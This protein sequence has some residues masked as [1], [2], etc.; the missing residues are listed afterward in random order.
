MLHDEATRFTQLIAGPQDEI[1]LRT[2]HDSL[3]DAKQ[4]PGHKFVGSWQ[5]CAAMIEADQQLGY[6]AYMVIN[7][8]GNTD[9]QITHH[10]ASFVDI[11]IYKGD[12]IPSVWHIEP[13]IITERRDNANA[14]Q[15]MHAYWLT[16]PG[17]DLARWTTTQKQLAQFYSSDAMVVNPSRVMRVPGTW[18]LKSVP[19]LYRLTW[20]STNCT[21]YDIGR[22]QGGLPA[23][24]T[25]SP[26]VPAGERGK[27][28]LEADDPQTQMR[29]MTYL[30]AVDPAVEGEGGDQ[31][32][33]A[34]AARCREE[35]L[36]VEITIALMAEHWNPR[37]QP[38]WD[39]EELETKVHN[40]YAYAQKPQGSANAL[41]L[42]GGLPDQA[43]A[44]TT[45]Q[46]PPGGGTYDKNHSVNAA[47]F[48][49]SHYPGKLLLRSQQQFYTYTGKIWESVSDDYIR[50]QIAIAVLGSNPSDGVIN[51]TF[52][53]LCK[54]CYSHTAVLGTWPGH[55]AGN[56]IVYDNGILNLATSELLPHTQEY[57][58]S[59]LLP[60]N[61]DPSAQ[62]PR[63][64]KFINEIFDCDIDRIALLQ[65]WLG[66]MLTPSN[67]FQKAMLL[68]GRRRSGKG[69]IGRILEHLVGT[70]NYSGLSLD[71]LANDAI[72]ESILERRV[73]F[74]GDAH[75]VK[76]VNRGLVLDRFNSIT[77][78][79]QLPVPRKYIGAWRGRV[80]G[81]ITM[82]ANATPSFIDDS[83]ALASR[84]LILPFNN[85]W[86]GR[87]NFNLD[88]ELYAEIEG[89]NT[90]ALAGL[91][92]L[93]HLGRFTRPA[94]SE[95]EHREL[96][97]YYSPLMIFVEECCMLNN[98]ARIFT[99]QLYST[100][101]SWCV[102][103]GM[104]A[105]HRNGF[106]ASMRSAFRGTI[107][108]GTIVING[109]RAQGFHGIGLL[110]SEQPA[111]NVIPLMPPLQGA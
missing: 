13:H 95:V 20:V 96:N 106:T 89:I 70:E 87:E 11:D 54:L 76:G 16:E 9:A 63:W 97:T 56:M 10:R 40:A 111:T 103:S 7:A 34:V 67:A 82:A 27:V 28:T 66:Y 32:T 42:F 51:G 93:F 45:V 36:P 47:Q 8:G 2:F 107:R 5:Q 65:E 77:G 102:A 30:I 75:S 25:T 22:I 92:R 24:A 29:V 15:A 19:S 100:Y 52:G 26:P 84:F 4:Y 49:V 50:H 99:D 110:Q 81:R 86:L 48:I 98:E 108:K 104:K 88:T 62:A 59:T 1:H 73:L 3:R 90:W 94:L 21:A 101:R 46:R 55:D 72:L 17:N 85:S 79:D 78:G 57:F 64:E 83:G 37:C 12:P 80:P 71:G 74:M 53:I 14:L 41:A 31:H 68:L 35:G 33:F 43:L 23:L 105:Q 58:T 18:H 44:A 109:V 38:P 91:R 6:G 61:Y 39:Y 69:T 60:Y